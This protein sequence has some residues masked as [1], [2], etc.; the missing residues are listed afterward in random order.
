MTC[1]RRSAS[2]ASTTCP[3]A[4]RGG[5]HNVAGKAVGD[6]GVVVDLSTMG[7]VSVDPTKRM[8]SA[9]GVGSKPYT[10][11]Q[12]MLDATGSANRVASVASEQCS[13]GDP[14]S[15]GKIVSLH[16]HDL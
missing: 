3:V 5:G 1:A 9:A 7:G 14:H 16:N 4:V 8:A 13:R 10:E 6:D 12:A 2:P 15:G 11:H